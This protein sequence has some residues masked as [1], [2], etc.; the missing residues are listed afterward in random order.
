MQGESF[1]KM[2]EGKMNRKIEEAVYY[3]Y[4]MHMAHHDNPGEMA[5]RTKT[6]KPIYF[7]GCDYQG[8]NQ[9]P[10]AWELYDLSADPEEL[11]NLYGRPEHVE[12][13]EDLKKKL[14]ELRFELEMMEL[15]TRHVKKWFKNSGITVRQIEQRQFKSPLIFE[16]RE[17]ELTK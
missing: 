13:Q 14:K 8:K 17:T 1:R 11:N 10:P 15:I 2:C 12:L 4:W 7:Y 16:R 9:T 5:I 6:H 3:R